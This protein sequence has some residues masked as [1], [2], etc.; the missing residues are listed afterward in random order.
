MASGVAI[1]IFLGSGDSAAI[2]RDVVRSRGVG[3]SPASSLKIAATYPRPAR[4]V[5]GP[6]GAG[7]ALG[8]LL[9]GGAIRHGV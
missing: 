5:P 3:L 8:R 6:P 1:D 2:T 7:R 4:F 9:Q